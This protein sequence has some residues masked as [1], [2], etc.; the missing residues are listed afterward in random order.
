MLSRLVCGRTTVLNTSFLKNALQNVSTKN[1]F[2]PVRKYASNPGTGFRT[3]AE[4][5]AERQTLKERA[6]APPG[7]DAYFNFL[8]SS[9]IIFFL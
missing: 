4:R 1:Q 6:M 3:R 8:L 5:I 2:V 7:K 9:L